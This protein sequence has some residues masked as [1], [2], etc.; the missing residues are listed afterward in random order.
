[1]KKVLIFTVA[2]LIAQPVYAKEKIHAVYIPLADHYPAIVA[3]EK[4]RSQMKEADFIINQKKSWR[5]LRGQ[6]EAGR[7]DMAFIISPMAMDMFAKKPD[8]RWV[9]LL[10]RD[11]NALAVNKH[12]EQYLSL[13]ADRKDRK[14]GLQVAEAFTQAK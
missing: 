3:Y 4:Y 13:P 5:S 7:A 14:P 1:M 8:F 6:F 9:S 12:M 11:G 2:F 10:H